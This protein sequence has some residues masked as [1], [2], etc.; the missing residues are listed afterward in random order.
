MRVID[1][2]VPH[3]VRQ[4]A[5][6]MRVGSDQPVAFVFDDGQEQRSSKPLDHA[7]V[8][9][10]VQEAA[11]PETFVALRRS[12]EARFSYTSPEGTAVEV[13]VRIEG[14]QT[15]T[16]AVVLAGAS[17]TRGL[18]LTLAS[19]PGRRP[20]AR[21]DAIALGPELGA[22]RAAPVAAAPPATPAAVVAPAPRGAPAPV[23]TPAAKASPPAVAPPAAAPSPAAP[24]ARGPAPFMRTQAVETPLV[25][26]SIDTLLEGLRARGASDVHIVAERPPLARVAGALRPM[27]ELLSAAEVE[28]LVLPI[29]PTRLRP[30]LTANGAV[31]FSF[32]SPG[33][34]RSRV[35]LGRQ[36]TGL[37]AVFRLIPRTTPTI[38]SLGLPPDLRKVME[39]HQGLVVITGPTGHGKTTTLA[40]LVDLINSET[41]HHVITVE[42]PVEYVHERKRAMMSQREV[43]SHTRS[44]HAALKGSLRED[45]DVIVVGELRDTETVRIALSASETG[46]LVIGTMNTPSAAKTIDRLIDLFPPGDQ[47]Q[48]RMTLAGGLRLVVSQRLVPRLDGQGMAVAV[49]LLPGMVPLW[50]LIRD[51]KTFQIPSLQQRGKG[52]GIIRLDDSLVDLVKNGVTSLESAREVADSPDEVTAAVERKDAPETPAAPEPTGGA[53]GLFGNVFG[54]KKG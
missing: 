3:L 42:D 51:G 7:T 43:G 31:D 48:V 10:L 39:H 32:E 20:A 13:A 9:R 30:D 14:P 5:R 24:P 2:Y 46:H 52:L 6:S 41:T 50:N 47:P 1:F 11:P 18:E 40:A 44:F 8:L 37:K 19:V 26:D 23:A 27:G 34:G 17:A 45:P 53:R 38:E 22:P 35:N 21:P 49:E 12:D 33:A 4:A 29:V 36:R 54:G 15:W 28:R 25:A 16:V